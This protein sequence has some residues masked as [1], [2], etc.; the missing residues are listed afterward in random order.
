MVPLQL[1][2]PLKLPSSDF[3]GGLVV[4]TSPSSAGAQVQSLVGKLRSPMPHATDRRQ[5]NYQKNPSFSKSRTLPTSGQNPGLHLHCV[6]SKIV[7]Y[8]FSDQAP[9]P[10]LGF[11]SPPETCFS[12]SSLRALLP[13]LSF[14]PAQ[15]AVALPSCPSSHPPGCRADRPNLQITDQMC[16]PDT[17]PLH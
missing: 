8:H 1:F 15:P 14:L 12:L 11:Y 17:D 2:F 6:V 5:N 16:K 7:L 9:R 4:M 13:S 10:Y 3:P